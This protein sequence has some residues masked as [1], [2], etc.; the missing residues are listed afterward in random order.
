MKLWH[1]KTI[2][3]VGY[4]L[5]QLSNVRFMQSKQLKKAFGERN[6]ARFALKMV[7]AASDERIIFKSKSHL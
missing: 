2:S 6:V 1:E 3:D 7:R 5:A 4:I